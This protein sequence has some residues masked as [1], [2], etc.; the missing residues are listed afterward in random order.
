QRINTGSG[1]GLKLRKL[2]TTLV[3]RQCI[4]RIAHKSDRRLVQ[5]DDF[6]SG[7]HPQQLGTRFDHS[8]YARVFVQ[9]DPYRYGIFQHRTKVFEPGL[10]KQHERGHLERSR[11]SHFFHGWDRRLGKL[12]MAAGAPGNDTGLPFREL[13]ERTRSDAPGDVGITR[14]QLNDPAAMRWAAHDTISD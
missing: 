6:D 1:G 8:F 11:S 4:Q 5:V 10:Q 7:Y 13:V 9:C 14:A 2:K 3:L 12:D